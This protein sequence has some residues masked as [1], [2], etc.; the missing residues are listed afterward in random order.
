[1]SGILTVRDGSPR[2]AER[3]RAGAPTTIVAYGT[4]MTL[5]GHYL[6]RL[7]GALTRAGGNPSIRLVNSGLRGYFTFA[8]AF[9]VIDAV[10]P[11]RPDLVL[12]EFAHNDDA[13]D[14]LATI[15]PAIDAMVAHVRRVSPACEFAF[16]YLAPPGVAAAGP[17]PAM[18]AYERVAGYYGFPSF[19]LAGLSEE[20]VASGRAAWTGGSGP[21]LTTDGI[22]HSEAAAELL[23]G[24]FA[25]A[26]LELLERSS[27]PA[28][29]PKPP[30]DRSLFDTARL[31]ISALPRTGDWSFGVPPNHEAR[32]CEAY[33]REVAQP[34][35][36]GAAFRVTF[37]GTQVFLW[38][39]GRGAF[40]TVLAGA[41]ERHRVEVGSGPAWSIHRISPRLA[42]GEHELAV[43]ALELPLVFGDVFVIGRA[44][45]GTPAP[46]VVN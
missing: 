9:R 14:A 33:D 20:L 37:A 17:S 19:D 26:F 4:S 11:H 39:M 29:A 21:V 45:A 35:A 24:P 6:A 12:I 25:A 40:E 36:P 44:P 38:A 27:G 42:P 16:V 2:F 31:P 30:R 8:A 43:T 7:P 15:A 1:M 13:P 23:G 10:L 5:F 46:G 34:N 22:H 28:P 41:P 18:L 32:T 3:V